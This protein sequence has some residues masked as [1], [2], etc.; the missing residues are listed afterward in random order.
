MPIYKILGRGGFARVEKVKLADGS[1]LARKVFDPSGSVLA[2]TVDPAK[3]KKRFQREVR[4]Q[5]NLSRE[6]PEYFIPVIEAN[7]AATEPWFS[8]PL[9]EQNL[10]CRIE[11]DRKAGIRPVN[12]LADIL[13]ALEDLHR[14]GYV[15]R[16]LKPSNVLLH[17]GRWKLA[18]FGLT[19]PPSDATA[20]LTS[21][22][23]SWGSVHYAAPEQHWDFSNATPSADIYSFGCILH[24]IFVGTPRIPYR[25]YSAPPPFGAI[26]ERC[27]A[28]NPAHRYKSISVLREE[29][30]GLLATSQDSIPASDANK[31]AEALKDVE[32]WNSDKLVDLAS[33][34]RS[35][36]AS[37]IE[38][39]FHALTK[40]IFQSMFDLDAGAWQSIALAYCEWAASSGFDF[41]Y[42]DVIVNRLE[43][44]FH[45]GGPDAKAAAA[46]SAASLGRSHNRWFVMGR[47]LAMCSPGLDKHVAERIAVEIET[48]DGAA[49]NFSKCAERLRRD[50]SGYHPLIQAAITLTKT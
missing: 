28:L 45:Q 47:V 48:E 6:N 33:F 27:T 50:I 4:I 42:C 35:K 22:N 29:L 1:L 20:K 18:D 17:D 46:V 25:N 16:D 31:W 9:A 8:M 41:A 12:A 34:V 32:T 14:L 36:E 37:T 15:H 2:Q 5:S 30:L 7:L 43:T 24:D 49:D 13:N 26:I 10:D 21:T 3:L 11:Q 40:K 39:I 23:S 19:L 44:I 38:P